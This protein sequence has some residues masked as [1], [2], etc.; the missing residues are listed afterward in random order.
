MNH[1]L[2]SRNSVTKLFAPQRYGWM[3][4]RRARDG[5]LRF[6]RAAVNEARQAR[7]GS[8]CRSQGR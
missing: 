8:C 3:S 4:S 5:D 1:S 6:H 2:P 7:S